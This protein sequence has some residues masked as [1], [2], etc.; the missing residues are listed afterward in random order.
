MLIFLVYHKVQNRSDGG[1]YTVSPTNLLMHIFKA[2]EGG[3]PI[4]NPRLLS[5]S[6]GRSPSGVI[7]T[8]DDGTADHYQTVSPLLRE[9]GIHALFYVPT[10]KLNRD[11][12]LTSEQVRLLWE[13]G[14]TI[15]SHSHTHQRLDVLPRD[16][17]REELESSA[18]A[19]QNIVGQR[20]VHFAP[21]GG[22]Y[23][24]TV[25]E[26]AQQVGYAFFRTMD[27]GYNKAF[28]PTRIEVVPLTGKLGSYVL[29]YAFRGRLQWALKSVC[30][31]KNGFRTI[32]PE[33]SYT[34]LRQRILR[35]SCS[36]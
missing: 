33:S 18:I 16:Q 22:F 6:V 12:Y 13:S 17:L 1:I 15:G 35:L 10:A 20:P 29:N 26:V 30:N 11:K 7:F 8:F 34:K 19:I 23:N 31:L 32:V 21:P 27:W 36:I 5:A 14:H 24:R 25:L 3:L 2:Q 9:F 4:L 28:E